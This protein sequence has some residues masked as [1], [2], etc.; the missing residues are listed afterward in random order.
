MLN[1]QE[2]RLNIDSI[3]LCM[4]FT[5]KKWNEIVFS[6]KSSNNDGKAFLILLIDVNSTAALTA[7]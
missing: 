1:R 3:K 6:P 4:P 2:F 7:F 5:N